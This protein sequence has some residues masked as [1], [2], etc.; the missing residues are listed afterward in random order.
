MNDSMTS[1]YQRGKTNVKKRKKKKKRGKKKKQ[2][3]FTEGSRK[4][5][6]NLTEYANLGILLW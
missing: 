6:I 3:V 5:N 4:E 2:A 1:E